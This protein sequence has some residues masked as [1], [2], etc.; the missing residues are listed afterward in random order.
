MSCSTRPRAQWCF[1]ADENG[2]VL[3]HTRGGDFT[4]Q[5]VP[6]EILAQMDA[7]Q[8]L[9]MAGTLDGVY[10]GKYYTAGRRI[11][12]GGTAGYLFAA[13]PMDALGAYVGDMLIMFRHLG[14]GHSAAVQLAVL[15]AGAAYHR[16]HR[17]YQRRRA[18]PGQRRFHRPRPGGRL[19]GTGG[20]RHHL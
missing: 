9:F 8:D 1:V 3:L 2:T 15:G 12:M 6:R 4:A 17:G 5:P 16:P 20:F 10:D 11:D 18:P 13:S 14:G 19:C 7:G